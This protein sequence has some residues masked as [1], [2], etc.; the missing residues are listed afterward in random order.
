S[1]FA[2]DV[3]KGLTQYPKRLSSKYIYDEKG[4]KLFQDIMAM[5]EYYLTDCEYSILKTHKDAIASYF[6]SEEGFDLIEVGAGDGKKAKILLHH[7]VKNGLTFNYLPVDISQ[8]ILD[9]LEESLAEELPNLSVETLQ[10]T[11]F[12]VLKD[13][14]KYTQ[15]K[16][17]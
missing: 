3:W 7:F 13:I 16:K 6:A 14:A 8:H 5:P 11:Y 4:D 15:R 1:K 17:V 10:G 9:G 2:E 12:E